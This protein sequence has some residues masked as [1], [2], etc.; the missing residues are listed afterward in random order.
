MDPFKCS[1]NCCKY[2]IVKEK[3]GYLAYIFILNKK[4]EHWDNFSYLWVHFINNNILI[5]PELYISLLLL[6]MENQLIRKV[7]TIPFTEN[8]QK[9][10]K[11]LIKLI[12]T[13]RCFFLGTLNFLIII[14][15]CLFIN[16]KFKNNIIFE[17]NFSIFFFFLPLSLLNFY[18]FN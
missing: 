14:W 18:K 7:N 10:Y 5:T 12:Y 17:S 2:G 1:I 15:F 6:V 9:Y 13:F 8:N 11:Y 4:G 16:S 3:N